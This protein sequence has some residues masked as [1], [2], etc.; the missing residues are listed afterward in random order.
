MSL[1]ADP[2]KN[3]PLLGGFGVKAMTVGAEVGC[4]TLV[5]VLGAVFGGLW[6]DRVFDTKPL[7]T[8]LLVL[9]SVPISL[10]LTFWVATRAVKDLNIKNS[11]ALEKSKDDEGESEP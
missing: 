3:N 10:G 4:L 6:L 9:G 2:F 7:I 8:I 1:P 5:I 11:K